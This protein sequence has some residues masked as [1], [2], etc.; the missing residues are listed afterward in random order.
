MNSQQAAAREHRRYRLEWLLFGAIT[1]L[2]LA[3]ATYWLAQSRRDIQAQESDRLRTQARVVSD[4]LLQQFAGV[5]KALIGVRDDFFSG[6]GVPGMDMMT[7]RRLQALTDALPGVRTMF[8]QDAHGKIVAANRPELTGR[9]FAEREYFSTPRSHPNRDLLYVSRPFKSTLGAWVVNL[10]RVLTDANGDFAGVVVAGLDPDHF[11]VVLRSVLYAPDMRTT[12]AHGDGIVF[13]NMPVNAALLGADIAK[14]GSFFTRHRESGRG[15][16][17][18]TGRVQATGED[19]MVATRTIER[20]GLHLDR[21][22]VVHVSR[23]LDA[24][25]APWRNEVYTS[26]AALGL[27]LAGSAAAL[28]QLQR[29]R[30]DY[31]A[32]SR[33]ARLEREDHD[34]RL[35]RMTDSIPALIGYFDAQQNAK[36]F[37]TPAMKVLGLEPDR[38]YTLREAL[39]E[40]SYA[41]HAPHL[42][43]VL[44]GERTSFE[45]EAVHVA[46]G[47]FILINLVPDKQPDGSVQ[48]FYVMSFDI[49]PLK[50]AQFAL[51][52]NERLLRAVTDNLPIMISYIDS[53]ERL[54]FLNATLNDWLG[55]D[56]E[57]SVGKPLRDVIGESEYEPRREYLARALKGERVEFEMDS[58]ALGVQRCLRVIYV[59]DLRDDGSVAGIYGMSTDVSALKRVERQL[60]ALARIDTLTG[61]PNRHQFNEKLHEGL[62]K[63]RET[64]DALGLLFL[65]V[66]HFKAINDSLGHAAGDAVLREFGQRLQRAVRPTDCVARLA[67]DE[68]VII[69]EGLRGEAEPQFVARKILAQIA[70]VFDIDGR[71]LSVSTSVGIA[72]HRHGVVSASELLAR[73]DAA[74][75]E[76]KAA[77]RN[78]YRVSESIG[79]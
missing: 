16:T 31:E 51:A 74:L 61:L 28:W 49:T 65:D 64:G 12:L 38:P 67:G 59:P 2:V 47:V 54:R 25:Y 42:D 8:V 41:L 33:R 71:H 32:L 39:G 78:T 52:D 1:L 36:F 5:D 70:H 17:L 79:S 62:A 73:A 9:T 50:K 14:P 26:A 10:T 75:Y 72:F 19:R 58:G 7:V 43:K 22:M 13:L 45:S 34:R 27:V 57:K 18:F 4:N 30:R 6:S 37:N 63:V 53:Q 3:F 68:F 77:G 56:T 69:L 23:V 46:P 15:D 60:S 20:P 48:G 55:V 66:D 24:I 11:D 29:R 35:R 76:A 40:A 44:Q 21:P